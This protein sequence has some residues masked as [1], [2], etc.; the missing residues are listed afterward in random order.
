MQSNNNISH[1]EQVLFD[2]FSVTNEIQ[3]IAAQFSIFEIED[4]EKAIKKLKSILD[5]I[6]NTSQRCLYNHHLSLTWSNPG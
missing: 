2:L 5:G 6:Y 4:I 3:E 1:H